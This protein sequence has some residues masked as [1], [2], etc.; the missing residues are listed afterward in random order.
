[1]FFYTVIIF[2]ILQRLAELL[3][4][5]RNK[6]KML[7]KGAIEYDKEGYKNIVIMHTCFFLSLITEYNIF[8][9][10]LNKFYLVFFTIFIAVQLMRYWIIIS[11][12]E[13][14]NTRII[15]MK[16]IPLVKK[17]PYKFLKHPNYI[18]VAIELAVLPLMFSCYV[19]AG[20]FTCLNLLVLKRRIIIE[21]TAL[22][23]R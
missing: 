11:L 12:G 6:K 21:E 8:S 5:K 18:V 13:F 17:G 10:G 1:M 9:S 4:A 3:I 15:V 19:T 16:N 23:M 22:G 2:V 7:A 20:L 14:W